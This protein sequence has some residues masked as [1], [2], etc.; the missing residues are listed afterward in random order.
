MRPLNTK[1][2]Q[3]QLFDQGRSAAPAA[4]AASQQ[5]VVTRYMIL[6]LPQSAASTL[7][8]ALAQHPTIQCSSNLLS[9]RPTAARQHSALGHSTLWDVVDAQQLVK[10]L[11]VD[12]INDE[13]D[14][15]E[16]KLGA[17]LDLYWSGSCYARACGFNLF[18][19]EL[20]CAK[21]VQF[22][23]DH[24]M[25]AAARQQLERHLRSATKQEPGCAI[26][27]I[28][29]Q[30]EDA[31]AAYAS[32]RQVLQSTSRHGVAGGRE[33]WT[34]ASPWSCEPQENS[35]SLRC[36]YLNQSLED[37]VHRRDE[38]YSWATG[39]RRHGVQ[40]HHVLSEHVLLP[41]GAACERGQKCIESRQVNLTTINQVIRFL[42]E[43]PIL[44]RADVNVSLMEQPVQVGQ[45]VKD[46]PIA[47]ARQ[48]RA[49]TLVDAQWEL[50]M[51]SSQKAI[52]GCYVTRYPD[53]LASYCQGNLSRCDWEGVSW[54][55]K[56]RGKQEGR[57]TGGCLR[58]RRGIQVAA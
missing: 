46:D 28:L 55:H 3:E 52:L 57:E 39:L 53:L 17:A 58:H 49:Y 5:Q 30:R 26:K 8:W 14:M 21:Q 54:H 51:P 47:V 34:T 19:D 4:S 18:H 44:R 16:R 37:Y 33:N 2:R 24:L 12:R 43:P 11:D 42:N 13:L 29:L 31:S 50:W 6:S 1:S 9:D 15:C 20:A 35:T 45:S 23:S 41:G 38:W 10:R 48:L 22:A 40:V 7:C 56:A 25:R 32:F 36:L 27:I